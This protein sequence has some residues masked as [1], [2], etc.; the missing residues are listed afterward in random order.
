M[1]KSTLA[2][3]YFTS[4]VRWLTAS[5]LFAF[6]V[7]TQGLAFADSLYAW[8]QFESWAIE[9]DDWQLAPDIEN[10]PSECLTSLVCAGI[11]FNDPSAAKAPQTE[12][13]ASKESVT[14]LLANEN[15]LISP[16]FDLPPRISNERLQ[17]WFKQWYGRSNNLHDIAVQI[18]GSTRIPVEAAICCGLMGD[19]RVDTR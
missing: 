19:R 3:Q 17:L 5:W 12:E 14:P 4:G 6:F 7:G 1:N 9:G 15:R 16:V 8:E 11:L 18:S 10:T 2:I 13:E